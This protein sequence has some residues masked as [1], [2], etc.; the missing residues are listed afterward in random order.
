MLINVVLYC[1]VTVK[2]MK[3]KHDFYGQM[4]YYVQTFTDVGLLIF[5]GKMF[6]LL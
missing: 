3:L 6:L 4:H 2:N 1:P 5:L